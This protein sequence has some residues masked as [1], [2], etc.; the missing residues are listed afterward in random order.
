MSTKL[1][2]SASVLYIGTEIGGHS[3][4]SDVWKATKQ[5]QLI[6]RL[7][8]KICVQIVLC[9]ID[10]IE[11]KAIGIFDTL[12]EESKLPKPTPDHFTAEV[13]KKNK[14]HFRLAVRPVKTKQTNQPKIPLAMM[15]VLEF[16]LFVI[17]LRFFRFHESPNWSSTENWEMRKVSWFVTL[18]ELCATPRYVTVTKL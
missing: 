11:G 4:H 2:S 9:F 10:L 18:L 1:I 7:L 15:M 13:H 16:S 14:S 6:V 3:L 5:L 12:D 8:N 17:F